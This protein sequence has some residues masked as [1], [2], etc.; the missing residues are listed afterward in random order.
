[1]ARPLVH[2]FSLLLLG[3]AAADV[4]PFFSA[5]YAD[6]SRLDAQ[7]VDA[8]GSILRVTVLPPGA[9]TSFPRMD[10]T[11]P[12]PLLPPTAGFTVTQTSAFAILGTP[13]GTLNVSLLAPTTQLLSAGGALLSGE[14]QPYSREAESACGQDH[15]GPIPGGCLRAYRTL[16]D[17]EAI[18]GF[19]Q[20]SYTVN[21]V[22][23]T[24]V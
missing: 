21:H 14:P 20:Q 19:G 13:M 17:E 5:T 7:M 8:A 10:L 12:Q 16:Q 4:T 11:V 23:T 24:K 6:G 9:N 22:G 1:M 18:F 15:G 2:F 3:C